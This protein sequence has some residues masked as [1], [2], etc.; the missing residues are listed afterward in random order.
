MTQELIVLKRE[1]AAEEARQNDAVPLAAG[2]ER[3]CVLYKDDEMEDLATMATETGAPMT[4]APTTDAPV[5]A[6]STTMEKI[7]GMDYYYL[8]DP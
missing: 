5:T 7:G 1:L 4:A 2:S 3:F 6:A 8:P